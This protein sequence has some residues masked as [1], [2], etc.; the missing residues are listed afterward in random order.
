MK[1]VLAGIFTMIT[2]CFMLRAGLSWSRNPSG[3]DADS[4]P[5]ARFGDTRVGDAGS[6]S[7]AMFRHATDSIESLLASA[8]DGDA[9]RYLGCFGGSLRARLERDADELGR[10]AFAA[11][12]RRAGLARSSHAIFAP[13]PDADRTDSVRIAVESTYGNRVESLIFRLEQ[14]SGGWIVTDVETARQRVPAEALG[15]LATFEAPEGNP[16]AG[17]PAQQASDTTVR[18]EP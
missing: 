13:E 7:Q 14:S 15:S 3:P 17:E 9:R 16:L 8:R 2:V 5:G 1:R 6:A 18:P 10:D 11:Q 4:E 12:L